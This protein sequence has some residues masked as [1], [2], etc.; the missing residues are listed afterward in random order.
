M[1]EKFIRGIT[2]VVDNLYVEKDHEIDLFFVHEINAQEIVYLL[3][4]H[5]KRYDR[6]LG[7]VIERAP[8]P[9]D[10]QSG[11]YYIEI[12]NK[13]YMYGTVTPRTEQ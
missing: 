8:A 13:L 12:W 2:F 11:L 9:D 1:G 10:L 5:G 7:I 4:Q 6:G 3:R